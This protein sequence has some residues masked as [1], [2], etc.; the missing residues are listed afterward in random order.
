MAS[1]REQA[2]IF[3][4]QLKPD[5]A[6]VA[7]NEALAARASAALCDVQRRVKNESRVARL[8]RQRQRSRGTDTYS[9]AYSLNRATERRPRGGTERPA[10]LSSRSLYGDT[11]LAIDRLPGGR[12]LEALRKVGGDSRRNMSQRL[13]QAIA[14][15]AVTVGKPT[16]GA[17]LPGTAEFSGARTLAAR[18]KQSATHAN[19]GKSRRAKRKDV[20]PSWPGTIAKDVEWLPTAGATTGASGAARALTR[21]QPRRLPQPGPSLPSVDLDCAGSA[22][23]YELSSTLSVSAW[24]TVGKPAPGIKLTPLASQHGSPSGATSRPRTSPMKPA[25]R[26]SPRVST[27]RVSIGESQRPASPAR[28]VTWAG[29]PSDGGVFVEGPDRFTPRSRSPAALLRD[30]SGQERVFSRSSSLASVGRPSPSPLV[31]ASSDYHISG[32]RLKRQ[33]QDAFASIDIARKPHSPLAASEQA[34]DFNVSLEELM[35]EY[36]RSRGS[37][38]ITPP[39]GRT[40]SRPGR[41]R[42]SSIA[43]QG[44]EPGIDGFGAVR[45]QRSRSALPALDGLARDFELHSNPIM[46]EQQNLDQL[47]RK[48]SASTRASLRRRVHSVS[49]V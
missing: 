8:S 3:A 13:Q 37:G 10:A 27:G 25:L 2:E 41:S 19:G 28:S 21:P 18:Q 26:Q 12:R 9:A 1:V 36:E 46:S 38:A 6:A 44:L 43:T 16:T 22:D 17:S 11:N 20:P 31:A 35:E 32:E 15:Q 45:A 5:K 7:T 4:L 47:T 48:L 24:H 23:L 34:V 29:V 40:S 14:D 39:G 33:I 49:G 42:A 30:G